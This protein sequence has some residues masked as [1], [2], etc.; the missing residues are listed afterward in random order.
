MSTDKNQSPA[1]AGLS[2][3]I[4]PAL[5]FAGIIGTVGGFVADVLSPIG[6]IITYLIYI[7]IGMLI[8][9]TAILFLL[10][11]S[12]KN[13]LKSIS[14]TSLFFAIIFILF[15]QV[16]EDTENGFLG[17]NIEFI[18][19]FQS[20]LNIIDEKLDK[21]SDQVAVVDEKID[22][23]DNKL[24]E[25]FNDLA[26]DV[27]EMSESNNEKLDQISYQQEE[28][29][30]SIDNLNNI[31][32]DLRKMLGVERISFTPTLKNKIES[33][34]KSKDYKILYN[35]WNRIFLDFDYRDKNYK[36][37]G[38]K[39]RVETIEKV[40][41][42]DIG[43][44]IRA[45][46]SFRNNDF[47]STKKLLDSA[48]AVNPKAYFSYNLRG[49][50]QENKLKIEDLNRAYSLRPDSFVINY[51]RGLYYLDN[52][53][54][55][56]A[57][58]DI[59]K[60]LEL[61]NFKAIDIASN[62]LASYW[63]IQKWSSISDLLE[64]VNYNDLKTHISQNI[65]QEEFLGTYNILPILKFKNSADISFIESDIFSEE[66][67]IYVGYFLNDPNQYIPYSTN[68]NGKYTKI[69]QKD[70]FGFGLAGIKKP[71]LDN[72]DI[73]VESG[74]FYIDRKN[75]NKMI[76]ELRNS[77]INELFTVIFKVMEPRENNRLDGEVLFMKKG[78]HNIRDSKE[79]PY[80]RKL[81]IK[82]N[83]QI[84]NW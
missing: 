78:V 55:S 52:K 46:N 36:S 79:I 22:I 57:I 23:I 34:L 59:Y 64:K 6:P 3:L 43:Y 21:I 27:K 49:A 74:I 4:K 80:F 37:K 31:G 51:T 35:F 65:G 28:V 7:S 53:D 17:D 47:D 76:S 81:Q 75:N 45:G 68:K 44:F 16:N 33:Q 32:D 56:K 2:K 13:S 50:L 41:N 11:A 39:Y 26:N 61:T 30:T 58:T 20:T 66:G 73:D 24:D 10:P 83:G 38:D 60:A 72:S 54:Y 48:L 15:G 29:L 18:A 19:E 77:Q 25:G 12:K 69:N 9:S 82:D 14:V 84:I 62:L 5:N 63:N 67:N 71:V 42:T 40:P 70:V 1:L 8:I